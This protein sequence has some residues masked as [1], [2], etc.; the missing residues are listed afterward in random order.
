MTLPPKVCITCKDYAYLVKITCCEIVGI[1][2]FM[3][4]PIVPSM[5]APVGFLHPSQQMAPSSTFASTRELG[6]QPQSLSFSTIPTSTS[7]PSSVNSVSNKSQPHAWP[8]SLQV[9]LSKV[10]LECDAAG[11]KPVVNPGGAAIRKAWT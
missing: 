1:D 9:F 2:A 5:D 4:F 10:L 8:S 7:S 11:A 6:V 3:G